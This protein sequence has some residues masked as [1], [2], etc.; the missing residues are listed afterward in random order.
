MN[1][2]SDGVENWYL[3]KVCTV[4]AVRSY[5]IKNKGF[6]M[7]TC[8]HVN[9]FAKFDLNS[10]FWAPYF[11]IFWQS[12]PLISSC[13]AHCSRAYFTHCVRWLLWP[14]C[15]PLIKIIDLPLHAIWKA[16]SP[17]VS[18][19]FLVNDGNHLGAWVIVLVDIQSLKLQRWYFT[20]AILTWSTEHHRAQGVAWKNFLP[21]QIYIYFQWLLY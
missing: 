20:I 10:M 17:I 21:R 8:F 11:K 16:I 13:F 2:S 14:V 4:H 7:V 3:S 12:S 19:L 5:I 1:I 9:N 18:Q 15:P 6:K